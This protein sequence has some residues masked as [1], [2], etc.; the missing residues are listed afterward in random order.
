[1]SEIRGNAKSVCELLD[2]KKYEIDYYQRDYKWE[3]KQIRELIED[4]TNRFLRDF[5]PDH[6]RK[7]VDNY[8]QYF[9]G[10]IIVSKK[11][12][13]R[14]IVDGQQRLTSIT[15]LLAYLDRLQGERDDRVDVATLIYSTSTVRG[16]ST[17]KWMSGSPA[18]TH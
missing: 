10:S 14:F 3:S 16:P 13:K 18:S 11:N 4:L 6:E 15:L 7:E 8:G 5:N 12:N 1:M 2:K 9:L 17:S